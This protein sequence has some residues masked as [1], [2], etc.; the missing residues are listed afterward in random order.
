MPLANAFF[1]LIKLGVWDAPLKNPKKAR[2]EN[3]E[4]CKSKTWIQSNSNNTVQLCKSTMF[5]SILLSCHFLSVSKCHPAAQV[6]SRSIFSLY[7]RRINASR[8]ASSLGSSSG[9]A[10]RKLRVS[11]IFSW[12]G[13]PSRNHQKPCLSFLG[14]N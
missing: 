8:S 5:F 7:A 6:A 9:C 11:W 14:L 1:A 3:K 13:H 12:D 10:S 4:D 2:H